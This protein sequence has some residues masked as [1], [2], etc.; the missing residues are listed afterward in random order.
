MKQQLAGTRWSL[1]ILVG[2]SA[3]AALPALAVDG[4]VEINQARAKVGAVTPGDTPKFPVTLD[5]PGSYRLTGNLDVTDATALAGGAAADTTAILV[6]ADNVTLDLNGFTIHG[7]ASCALAPGSTCT[8]TGSGHGVDGTGHVG[9]VIRNGTIEGM[10]S[11]GIVLG[12]DASVQKLYSRRN[13]G[14]GIFCLGVGS[15]V[16]QCRATGNGATGILGCA[17]T[18]DSVANNNHQEG[19]R[20]GIVA[21]CFAKTN[22]TLASGFAEIVADIATASE[23]GNG[24]GPTD[25]DTV[26]VVGNNLCSTSLCP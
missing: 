12:D 15:I 6:T 22:G 11:D 23:G 16:D 20:G 17:I 14:D 2:A 21:R 13:G 19:I 24:T 10:G 4:V 26:G 8:S 3:M 7:P 5:H 25:I 18:T 9:T 1:A